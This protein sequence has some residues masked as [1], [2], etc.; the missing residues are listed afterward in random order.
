MAR[1]L[2]DGVVR[3]RRAHTCWTCERSIQPGERYRRVTFTESRELLS[4]VDCWQCNGAWIT[5]W[6]W[7]SRDRLGL[8]ADDFGELVDFFAED[9][10]DDPEAQRIVVFAVSGA[11]R[12]R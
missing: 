12:M 2:S 8:C 1:I 5:A 10:P 6:A 11:A 9:Y 3:A 4:R 7:N